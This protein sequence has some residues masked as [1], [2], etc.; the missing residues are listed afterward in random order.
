MVQGAKVAKQAFKHGRILGLGGWRQQDT[1]RHATLAFKA[2]IQTRRQTM[3]DRADL[4]LLLHIQRE[5]SLAG[6]SRALELAP[7]VVSKRLAALEARLGARLLHRTTRRLQLTAEGEAFVEHAAVLAEGFARLEETLSDRRN[8][9][10]G[11]LRVTSS[12]GFG[13]VC[14]APVLAGFQALHPGIEIQLHLTEHLPDLSSG[15]F[16][17]AVWLRRPEAASLVTR[18]LAH[19]RRVVVAAPSYLRQ[20]GTPQAPEDLTQHR[21]LVVREF[22]ASPASWAL[23]PVQA[24]ASGTASSNRRRSG[25]PRNIKVSG[26]LSSNHGE[27]VREWA[28]QGHGLML[29]SLWDVFAH[30]RR[31]ELVQVLPGWAML[32]ADL[33][34]VL[35]PRDLRLATPKRLRLLQEHLVAAFAQVPWN[36]TAVAAVAAA[37]SAPVRPVRARVSAARP[38]PRPGH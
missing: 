37:A 17:A 35:P 2:T 1:I 24:T 16:D 13:R 31:R 5:G 4:N 32:D 34:L 36:D 30:L 23:Q 9:A 33:H 6:A 8:D 10:R 7:P 29:R 25:V 21:C 20:H 19:N 15:R 14:L 28:L 26:P 3:I 27:V 18:K 12:F 38:K 22:D 11:L